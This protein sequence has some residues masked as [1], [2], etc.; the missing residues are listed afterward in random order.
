MGYTIKEFMEGW[1]YEFKA[2]EKIFS[3]L[4]DESLGKR[5]T[6]DN[7]SLGEIAWHI[8]KSLPEMMGRTGLTIEMP[9]EYK[10]ISGKAS[11]ILNNYRKVSAEF[12][13]EITGKWTDASLEEEDDMY[14]EKWKRSMTLH[15]LI[16]HQTHHR[17]QMTV[18]MRQAGMKVPGVYGPS[19][20][21]WV[22]YGMES[23][24]V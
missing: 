18:L 24:P 14:G 6:D 19:K 10:S 4:T 3:A 20:E 5:I 1:D 7:W 12:I 2:T 11:E 16:V 13:K 22:N 15:V 21:E 17:G 23:P 9:G 8:V